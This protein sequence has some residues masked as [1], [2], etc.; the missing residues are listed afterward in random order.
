MPVRLHPMFDIPLASLYS[1]TVVKFIPVQK[2]QDSAV[3][4]RSKFSSYFE[5]W[6]G[7]VKIYTDGLKTSTPIGMVFGIQT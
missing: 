5:K 6:R 1:N 7:Y 3:A 2:N 4:V